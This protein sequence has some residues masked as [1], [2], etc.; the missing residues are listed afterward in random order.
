[1]RDYIIEELPYRLILRIEQPSPDE[2][3]R[4]AAKGVEL[5]QAE[6]YRKGDPAR[7]KYHLLGD[8]TKPPRIIVMLIARNAIRELELSGHAP[9]RDNAAICS[10]LETLPDEG[11]LPLMRECVVRT[12]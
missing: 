8:T 7:A 3:P 4:I 12:N 5:L 6:G 9:T 1:M 11:L 10:W 2:V